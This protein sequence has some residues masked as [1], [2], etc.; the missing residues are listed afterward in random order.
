LQVQLHPLGTSAIVVYHQQKTVEGVLK[1]ARK[2]LV[3]EYAASAED[4][5]RAVGLR[6]RVEAHKSQYPGNTALQD[7]LNEWM[8]KF[9]NAEELRR[10]AAE[11]ATAGDG[12]TVVVKRAGRKRNLGTLRHNRELLHGAILT[13]FEEMVFLVRIATL[14]QLCRPFN[15][16]GK[17]RKINVDFLHGCR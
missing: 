5:P 14:I 7:S 12:W 8:E 2:G 15:N 13:S 1:A 9:E 11:K 16:H 6:A 10:K 4:G 3:V 17:E